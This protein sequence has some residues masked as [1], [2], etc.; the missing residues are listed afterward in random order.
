M[1]NPIVQNAEGLSVRAGKMG[2]QVKA[3]MP[4]KSTF[5]D[6]TVARGFMSDG[7]VR[8]CTDIYMAVSGLVDDNIIRNFIPVLEITRQM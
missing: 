7:T 3:F 2:G 5:V 1:A 6:A 4:S 8:G